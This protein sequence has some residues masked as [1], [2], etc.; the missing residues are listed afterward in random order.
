MFEDVFFRRQPYFILFA[1][2]MTLDLSLVLLALRRAVD[3]VA[4]LDL[5]HV[6]KAGSRSFPS[7]NAAAPCR[8]R[9]YAIL[10]RGFPQP[11]VLQ[12]RIPALA[13]VVLACGDRVAEEQHVKASVS[14]LLQHPRHVPLQL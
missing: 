9:L 7:L 1:L 4:V 13:A 10:S 14:R 11:Q 6:V 2:I 12:Q 3:R 5:H 8:L